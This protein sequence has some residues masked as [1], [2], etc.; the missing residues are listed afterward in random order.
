MAGGGPESKTG[1]SGGC[2]GQIPVRQRLQRDVEVD[3]GGREA[4]RLVE[5]SSAPCFPTGAEEEG[6]TEIAALIE[7]R[8]LTPAM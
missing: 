4:A 8:S 5:R 6:Y 1:A 3:H 2:L 7:A